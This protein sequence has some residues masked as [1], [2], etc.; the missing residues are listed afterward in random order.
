MGVI[1]EMK[2][3]G[4]LSSEDEAYELEN[5]AKIFLIEERMESLSYNKK[6]LPIYKKH[7]L[8]INKKN[9][10]CHN[11]LNSCMPIFMV[12]GLN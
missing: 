8:K 3:V 2:I 5:V 9:H 6:I 7:C 4:L 12:R 11:I 10:I 1:K